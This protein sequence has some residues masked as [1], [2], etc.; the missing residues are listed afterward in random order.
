MKA[1]PETI[2]RL[3]LADKSLLESHFQETCELQKLWRILEN[4]QK[5]HNK[6]SGDKQAIKSI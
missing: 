6:W 5:R 2:P 4:L 3:V 1:L